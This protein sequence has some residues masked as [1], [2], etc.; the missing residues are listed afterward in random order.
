MSS[1]ISMVTTKDKLENVAMN[2]HMTMG[3]KWGE[4][5][6]PSDDDGGRILT[7]VRREVYRVEIR[8]TYQLAMR[9]FFERSSLL[10]LYHY[11]K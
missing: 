2:F 9:R 1:K 7:T 3:T 11:E 10:D 5:T 6:A 8:A 4:Y